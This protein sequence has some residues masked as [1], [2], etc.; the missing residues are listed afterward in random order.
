[1]SFEHI[2]TI[3]KR[4]ELIKKYLKAREANKEAVIA[5]KT[6]KE[7]FQR[8]VVQPF[9]QPIV[10]AVQEPLRGVVIPPLPPLPP[11]V[12]KGIDVNLDVDI[13][14][15]VLQKYNLPKLSYTLSAVSPDNFLDTLKILDAQSLEFIKNLGRQKGT[16]KKNKTKRQEIE[17]DLKNLQTYRKRIKSLLS[18]H[19]VIEKPRKR[20]QSD[21]MLGMGLPRHPYKLTK[22]FKFGQLTI[23]PEKLSQM[24]LVAFQNGKKVLNKPADYDLIDLLQKRF[25]SKRQYSPAALAT[26]KKLVELSG[27]PINHRSLKFTQVVKGCAPEDL[28]NR[29]A[30]LTGSVDAGNKSKSITNEIVD[31]ITKLLNNNFITKEE[32]KAIYED[33]VA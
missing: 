3:D 22:D 27:L 23:D 10:E 30:V 17:N 28:A 7:E 4:N 21:P 6:A 31:L 11:P 15:D 16:T 9:T 2:K 33:Y 5:S 20:H 14:S 26:F 32:Y 25:N 18:E 8:D 24:K 29:L 19:R 13:N 1:M 12:E